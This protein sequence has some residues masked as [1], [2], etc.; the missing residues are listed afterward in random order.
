MIKKNTE[1]GDKKQNFFDQGGFFGGYPMPFSYPVGGA[2]DY[3]LAVDRQILNNMKQQS[4]EKSAPNLGSFGIN[5]YKDGGGIHI[6]HPG[7]LTAL[8]KRTG[9]TEAELWAEGKPE[10]RKMITFA[11]SSRQWRHSE[12]GYIVGKVYDLSKEEVQR[13]IR[14]GYEIEYL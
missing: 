13:L 6:K 8:K 9:K 11:R 14:L 2:L 1:K 12:G 10:V 5:Q 3:D 7:R 4:K